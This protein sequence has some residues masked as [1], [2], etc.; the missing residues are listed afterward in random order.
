VVSWLLSSETTVYEKG[1]QTLDGLLHGL[2]RYSSRK[3]FRLALSEVLNPKPVQA[4]KT[5]RADNAKKTDKEK[6]SP[7]KLKGKKAESKKTPGKNVAPTN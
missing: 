1:A 6:T 7:S 5:P 4:A 3:F 2:R